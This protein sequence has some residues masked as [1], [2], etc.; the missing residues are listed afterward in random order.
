[1]EVNYFTILYWFC[2]TSTWIRHR[3][4]C[5]LHPE[6]P[7]LLP[8][9]TIPLGRPSAPAPS[10]QDHASNLDWRFHLRMLLCTVVFYNRIR[11]EIL[12]I[13]VILLLFIFYGASQVVLVVKNMPASARDLRDAASISGSGRFS[14]RREWH[15]FS[16]LAWRIHGQRSLAVSSP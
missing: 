9:R 2:H 14:W 13:Q 10:I 6:P 11:G 7:S 4:T 8:P 5:V 3:Y 16:I 15:H 12:M 1:M